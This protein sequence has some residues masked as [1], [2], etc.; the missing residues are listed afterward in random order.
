MFEKTHVF[1]RIPPSQQQESC[2][3]ADIL[4]G[5]A[6]KYMRREVGT[7]ARPESESRSHSRTEHV[8][9]DLSS[10]HRSVEVARFE[11]HRRPPAVAVGRDED[12]GTIMRSALPSTIYDNQNS[13]AHRLE[14]NLLKRSDQSP[15]SKPS[16]PV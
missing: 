8:N 16:T 14:S 11:G 13:G 10:E 2:L 15:A 12:R 9:L 5:M 7:S 3:E 6:K 4:S 1:F